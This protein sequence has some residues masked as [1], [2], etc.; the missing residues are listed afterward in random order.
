MIR[1]IKFASVPVTD[2]DRAIAFYTEKLGFRLLADHPFDDKQ[3]WIELG[4][5]GADTRLVLF[6]M[7]EGIQPGGRMNIAFWTDDVEATAKDLE[8]KGVEF[9][10]K[11]QK[12]DWGTFAI[13]QDA[14]ANKFVMGTK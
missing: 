7:D 13:F 12:A 9:V 14:D 2:Q 4:I 8:A 10:V 3:R 1:G 5:P 11:P 6:K